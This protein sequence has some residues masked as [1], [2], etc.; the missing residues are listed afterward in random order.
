MGPL[1][2][3][4]LILFRPSSVQ[5]EEKLLASLIS[6]MIDLHFSPLRQVG[7]SSQMRGSHRMIVIARPSIGR[8]VVSRIAPGRSRPRSATSPI[9]G[10]PARDSARSVVV[11]ESLSEANPLGLLVCQCRQR[12]PPMSRVTRWSVPGVPRRHHVTFDDR[13]VCL[14]GQGFTP[15]ASSGSPVL[16][17]E[18]VGVELRPAQPEAEAH[19]ATCQR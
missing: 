19:L 1:P 10:I 14:Y 4:S 6:N 17:L 7:G 11:L 13:E 12:S 3:K 8:T 16:S 5:V 15:L 9:Q 18:P 2:L